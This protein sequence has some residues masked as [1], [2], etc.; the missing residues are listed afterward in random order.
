MTPPEA[1]LV[2]AQTPTISV[3]GSDVPD[4][5]L[6][7]VV[8]EDTLHVPSYA[9]FELVGV[10]VDARGKVSAGSAT[11]EVGTDVKITFRGD[12][13]SNHVLFDGA[14][15]VSI[16]MSADTGDVPVVVVR[17]YDK[18]H[19]LHGAPKTRAFVEQ[20]FSDIVKTVVADS[21]LSPGT[22]EQLGGGTQESFSQL[23]MTDWE[24]LQSV[25]RLADGVLRVADGK[26][27][28]Q[29]QSPARGAP[30]PRGDFDADSPLEL[31]VGQN[32]EWFSARVTAAEQVK[33]VAV[34]GWDRAQQKAIEQRERVAT[35]SFDLPLAPDQLAEKVG[36]G[37]WVD[38]R[39]P[40]SSPGLAKSRAEALANDIGEGFAEFEG[41]ATGTP[42]LRAGK[43]VS[44]ANATP[45]LNGRYT[46]TLARHVFDLVGGYRTEFRAVGAN[47]RSLFGLASGGPPPS[48][49]P[50]VTVGIVTDI[51][52]PQ[53]VGR[54]KLKLPLFS[55]DF[56]TGW[57]RVLHPGIGKGRG[58]SRGLFA[59]PHVNDEVFVAFEHGD[60]NYPIVLGAAF[61]E[62]ELGIP[63]GY[64]DSQKGRGHEVT[65]GSAE[66]HLLQLMDN[67]DDTKIVLATADKNMVITLSQ[68]DNKLSILCK[69]SDGIDV[70][71]DNSP[72]SIYADKDIK[73]ETKGN[74]EYKVTGNMK[75]DVKGN[76]ELKSG[77]NL[78]VEA[79]INATYKSGANTEIT[80]SVNMTVKGSSMAEYSGG[81]TTTIKGGTVLI[82]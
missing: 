67:P 56:E 27:H 19:R 36:G 60:V 22:V 5:L 73:V 25:A 81:G 43:P 7:R 46:L 28:F 77:Q 79:G 61:N 75:L 42:Q 29:Q 53:N 80:A 68:K 57:A 21:G 8:I 65:L 72:I 50:G 37:T 44:L 35:E 76:L 51:A 18:T 40:I 45:A 13:D 58:D 20:S 47:D 82:N 12:E 63:E 14:E 71:A 48:S 33:E 15:V 62:K 30:N 59:L 54:V 3:G 24:L 23:G 6:K 41:E 11:L 2:Q 74:V 52:D 16:G 4:E 26:V 38:A 69:A 9:E 78:K 10:E 17:A 32:L 39:V 66:G 49:F 34:R 70:K 64:K 1:V 31:T 55:E